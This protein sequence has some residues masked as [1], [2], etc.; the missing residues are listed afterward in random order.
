MPLGRP[1]IQTRSDLS[2]FLQMRPTFPFCVPGY[3]KFV[4][5]RETLQ[6]PPTVASYSPVAPN[7]VSQ[8]KKSR[9][10]EQLVVLRFAYQRCRWI[11]RVLFF[12]RKI[13]I[14]R[15]ME[16]TGR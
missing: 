8:S 3:L 7:Y 2:T 10:F 16:Q 9:V 1:R 6:L 13:E 11:N 4:A 12:K 15:K 14:D 5:R